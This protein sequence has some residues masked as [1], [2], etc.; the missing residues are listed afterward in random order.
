MKRDVRDSLVS[1]LLVSQNE[2]LLQ[3]PVYGRTTESGCH[4]RTRLLIKISRAG[5]NMKGRRLGSSKELYSWNGS[6]SRPLPCCGYMANVRRFVP[7][8]AP[9]FDRFELL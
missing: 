1:L 6:P 2:I 4:L 7:L 3:G 9:D 8:Q 5:L